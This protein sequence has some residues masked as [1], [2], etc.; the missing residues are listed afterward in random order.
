M[1]AAVAVSTLHTQGSKAW[2]GCTEDQKKERD[3]MKVKDKS[4]HRET[5]DNER[6]ER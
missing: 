3:Q 5:G 6:R 4:E 2:T 1:D